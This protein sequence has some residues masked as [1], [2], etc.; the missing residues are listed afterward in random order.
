MDSI[1]ADFAAG[2]VVGLWV[3][4]DQGG[5]EFRNSGVTH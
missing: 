3:K 2:I 5:H 1:R 4:D